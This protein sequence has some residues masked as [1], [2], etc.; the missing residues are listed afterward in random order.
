MEVIMFCPSCGLEYAQKL[1]YCKRCGAGLSLPMP[2]FESRPQPARFVG[3][4]WAVAIFGLGGLG[5]AF[6]IL[7]TMANFGR[8]DEEL[9]VPFVF[10][11]A[12][13]FGLVGLLIRQLSR[14][15]STYQQTNQ[16]VSAERPA[17]NQYQPA[18]TIAPPEAAP[19]VVEHTTRQFAPPAHKELI[20]RE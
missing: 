19:S 1:N 5:L 20:P 13:I 14:V 18:Q 10:S 12:F 15:V 7:A 11:L 2:P 8:H 4:F 3:L 16:M 17:I 6:G 9:I